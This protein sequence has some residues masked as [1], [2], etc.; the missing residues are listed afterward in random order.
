MI[1]HNLPLLHPHLTLGALFGLPSLQVL[2]KQLLIL[3][4]RLTAV[5]LTRLPEVVLDATEHAVLLQT[6]QTLEEVI[7]V[8]EGECILAIWGGAPSHLLYIYFVEHTKLGFLS[9][10]YSK[11]N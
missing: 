4:V 11:V 6:N 3:L 2:I 1:T 8:T 7:A 9:I 5:L 10:N